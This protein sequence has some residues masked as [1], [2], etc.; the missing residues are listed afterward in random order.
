MELGLRAAA[1]AL[2]ISH[3]ALLKA[4]KAG[5]V[6]AKNGRYNVEECRLALAANTNPVKSASARK[7]KRP[8]TSPESSAPA[9]DSLA[10]ATRRKENALARLRELELA[11]RE[12]KLVSI[13]DIEMVWSKLIA[14]CRARLLALPSRVATE[15]AAETSAQRCQ[16]I[17]RRELYDALAELSQSDFKAFDDTEEQEGNE[18]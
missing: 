13:D 16:E 15:L 9:G 2:G 10:E 5:R 6:T 12:G 3:P 14:T 8:A 4:T 18:G 11:E 1:K 7:Q 17:V